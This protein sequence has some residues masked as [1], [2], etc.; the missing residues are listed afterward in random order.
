MAIK[1]SGWVCQLVKRASGGR[2][3][4]QILSLT[5]RPGMDDLMNPGVKSGWDPGLIS[6]VLPLVSPMDRGRSRM[7]SG[8][9]GSPSGFD[10]EPVVN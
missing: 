2:R 3:L 6:G 8:S 10:F 5:I 1:F 7:T 4:T 9:F